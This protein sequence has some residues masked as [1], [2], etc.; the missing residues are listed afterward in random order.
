MCY[1]YFNLVQIYELYFVSYLTILKLSR[2]RKKNII[3]KNIELNDVGSLGKALSKADNQKIIFTKYGVPGDIVDIQ[4]RK[5]R[6][7][8]IEG[9]IVKFHNYSKKR[10]EPKCKHFELCGGC[11]WQNMKYEDQL[12]YKSKEVANNLER[13]AKI[14]PEK[15]LPIIKSDKKYY[16]RNKMEFSFS[17]S[18][19]MTSNEINSKKIINDKN[20]LGFHK[21][22]MWS[23]V[24]DIK[25]CFLQTNISNKIRNYIKQRSIE[26]GLDFFDLT[27]QKGDIRTLTIRTTTLNEIMVLIQFFKDSKKANRLLNDLKDMFPE[28]SSIMYV[29][30]SKKNDTIYDLEV[31]CY[32]GKDYISEKIGDLKFKI[33][34]KSFFQ[35]NSFQTIKLY[36]IVKRFANLKGDELIY[37]LYCGTGTISLF[38]ANLVKKVIGIE[39]VEDAVIAARENAKFNEIH[40]AEFIWGD[41][42][43]ILKNGIEGNSNPEIV[44]LDPPRNGLDK[45]VID[46]VISIKPSKIIYV[47]CNSSTQARDLVDLN[48]FYNFKLSQSIDMF[49]QTYHVENVVLLEKI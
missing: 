44:I 32:N 34:A 18:R 28:I 48:K 5:K 25:K 13:I 1:I 10:T 20:A 37:D 26:L 3:L 12:F 35:T 38:L 15:T 41:V 30:N 24:V 40:N 42:K 46:S 22:G 7:S 31:K 6:K 11:S 23:K 21:S 2:K 49:P 19:W 47:S 9:D 45:S 16:Y 17:N 4:V 43:K 14:S 33:S 29:I 8:Y 36:N 39:T 27:N